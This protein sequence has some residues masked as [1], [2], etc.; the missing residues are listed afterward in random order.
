MTFHD[1][2]DSAQNACEWVG[3]VG[4]LQQSKLFVEGNSAILNTFDKEVC[5]GLGYW[6]RL[7][8]C[9]GVELKLLIVQL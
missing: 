1:V 8:L 6:F 3:A 5:M 9:F 7:F 4:T 2:S